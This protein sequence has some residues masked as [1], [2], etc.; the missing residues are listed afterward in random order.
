MLSS[1]C[2]QC[3]GTVM[4]YQIYL[5]VNYCN[6]HF[7]YHITIIKSKFLRPYP[8]LA[9]LLKPF[10][11]PAL[12]AFFSLYLFPIFWIWTPAAGYSR[13]TSYVVNYSVT[14]KVVVFSVTFNNISIISWESVLLFEETGLS[15]ESHRTVASH[16]QTLPHNVVSRTPR[17]SG[18]QTHNFSGYRHWLH[19]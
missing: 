5:H 1:V 11:I 12:K 19:R 3:S 8:T 14:V 2:S 7:L 15:G 13:N 16:W 9:I 10:G 6:T 18:I 4:V 17:L